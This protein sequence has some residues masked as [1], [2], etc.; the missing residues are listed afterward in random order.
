MKLRIPMLSG[1]RGQKGFSIVEMLAVFT[2]LAVALLPLA[3]IQ[4]RAR[5]EISQSMRESQATQLAQDLIERT[6]GQGFANAAPDSSTQG[7]FTYA[8]NV[9]PDA[10]NPFL[11]EIQVTISWDYEGA[12][13]QL[14]MA[15]KQ[16]AR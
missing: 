6:R 11:Q 4:F 2:V 5:Q 12:T 3:S 9:V 10:T 14:T 8:V 15:S 16:A 13:Q 1:K 7:V